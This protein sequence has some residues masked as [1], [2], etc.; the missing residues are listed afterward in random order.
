MVV[1]LLR[2]VV[3]FPPQ[4]NRLASTEIEGHVSNPVW[5]TVTQKSQR[6]ER[7]SVAEATLL[8]IFDRKD[9]SYVHYF[10]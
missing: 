6:R 9:I 2:S 1:N 5:L 3:Q 7:G 4:F 10:V 8:G